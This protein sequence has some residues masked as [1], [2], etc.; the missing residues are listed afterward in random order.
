[1][2]RPF[3]G[4]LLNQL[5]IHFPRSLLGELTDLGREVIGFFM[6]TSF[7]LTSI[8]S[9]TTFNFGMAL[10]KLYVDR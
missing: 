3:C 4:V 5:L 6:L 10:R 7:T 8:N 9:K 1:M 2:A